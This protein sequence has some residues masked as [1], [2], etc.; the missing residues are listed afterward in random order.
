MI[1]KELK[2]TPKD[3]RKLTEAERAQV[4]TRSP[5]GLVLAAIAGTNLIQDRLEKGLGFDGPL[6]AYSP[7]YLKIKQARGFSGT[8]DLMWTGNMISSMTVK[9]HKEYSEIFFAR[10]V[11]AKKAAM[12]NKTRPFFGLNSKDEVVIKD[13]YENY[14][15]AGFGK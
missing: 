13:T 4:D 9:G 14:V 7:D 2:I 12:N 8:V 15:F 11:E 10:A 1:V 6:K 3:A 5:K